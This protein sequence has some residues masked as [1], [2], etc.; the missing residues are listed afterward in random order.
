MA[1]THTSGLP[2][3]K[4]SKKRKEK[5]RE[6]DNVFPEKDEIS[7][8]NFIRM[9]V[10]PKEFMCFE[11]NFLLYAVCVSLQRINVNI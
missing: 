4:K 10:Q 8:L 11:L 1:D 3:K 9:S 6:K 7:L 5:K 2:Q